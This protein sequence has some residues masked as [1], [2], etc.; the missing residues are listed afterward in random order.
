[1]KCDG[2]LT[3]DTASVNL[4]D[5]AGGSCRLT[6]TFGANRVTSR[7]GTICRINVNPEGVYQRDVSG[8]VP[9][10]TG[11]A[12]KAPPV[13]APKAK[14]FEVCPDPNAPCH[15]RAREFAGYELPFRLPARLRAGRQYRSAPFYAVIL[16]TYDEETCDADDRP[17]GIERERRRLQEIYP[18]RK[19]FG[20]YGGCVAAIALEL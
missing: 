17:A 8:E 16:K 12:T 2:R 3:G 19:V 14:G 10:G 13:A 11:R 15:T 5:W 9:A 4:S 7:A 20:S 1:M 18:A 6:L